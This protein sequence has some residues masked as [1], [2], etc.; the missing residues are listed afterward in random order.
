MA[1]VAA[2]IMT[3]PAV[4]AGPEANLAEIALLLSSRHISAVPVCKPDGALLGIVSE[5]DVLRPFRESER[6]R[7]DW[8]L[9]LIA[10]GEDLSQDFL[11]YLRRD[12]RS[13]ADVMTRHVIT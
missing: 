12:L 1:I 9:S 6:Q 11:D 13:A 10:E 4:I 3:S 8:W 5:G 2:E 7:R